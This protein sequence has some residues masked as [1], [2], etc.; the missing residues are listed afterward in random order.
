[1]H[2]TQFVFILFGEGERHALLAELGRITNVFRFATRWKRED[3]CTRT[4]DRRIDCDYLQASWRSVSSATATK[5]P[6]ASFDVRRPFDKA[7]PAT[8][9]VVLAIINPRKPEWSFMLN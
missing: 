4:I 8:L 1:M 5:S 2:I 6:I 3:S 9:V 7:K